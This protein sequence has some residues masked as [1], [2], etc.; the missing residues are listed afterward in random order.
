MK[1]SLNI[2]IV[3]DDFTSRK[4][5]SRY[6]QPYSETDVAVNGTEAVEAVRNALAE[7]EPYDLICLDI[8]MPGLDGQGTLL[9]I[10]TLES[11]NGIKPGHGAKI[12]MVTCVDDAKNIM[13]AFRGQCE[14]YLVKPISKDALLKEMTGLGLIPEHGL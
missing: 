10:R 1:T 6:L 7:N 13:Q 9:A 14:A 5:L 12:I 3:D 8:L 11:E 4:I 2:L